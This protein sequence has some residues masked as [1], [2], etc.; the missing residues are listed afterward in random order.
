ME[1]L[2]TKHQKCYVKGSRW[3]S[4]IHVFRMREKVFSFANWTSESLAH[5]L[6]SENHMV[7]ETCYLK[8]A[9]R[10]ES[11]GQRTVRGV[12]EKLGTERAQGE[13]PGCLWVAEGPSGGERIRLVWGWCQPVTGSVGRHF[14]SP[15][16]AAEW[17]SGLLSAGSSLSVGSQPG[18]ILSPRGH[19]EMSGELLGPTRTCCIAHRALLSVMRLP[20][21]GGVWGTDIGI[22]MAESLPCPEIITTLIIGYIPI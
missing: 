3:V 9:Q 21:W 10:G 1:T 13:T 8:K 14:T 20:A 6:Q 12:H 4:L 19:L 17:W 11:R 7:R 2:N 5:T 15:A 16:R 22:W 18:E